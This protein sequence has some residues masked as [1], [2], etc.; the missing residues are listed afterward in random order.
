MKILSPTRVRYYRYL[1]IFILSLVLTPSLA[2][3]QW[4]A[5][6]NESNGLPSITKGGDPAL[7]SSFVF[8]GKDWEWA[9][10]DTL[11][12]I[13][14]PGQYTLRGTNSNLNL[15]LDAKISKV[16]ENQYTWDIQFDAKTAQK[17]IVGGGIE[18]N[19]DLDKYQKD[20][21]QSQI[22][23][24]K[25]G[26]V[27]GEYDGNHI[28]FRVDPK[29]A[30]INFEKGNEGIIRTYFF[31]GNIP[32][33]KTHFKATLSLPKN[34]SITST[35]NERFGTSN[36]D[37]WAKNMLDWES[38]PIDLSFLN[39]DERPAGKH[40]F[41]KAKGDQ[42]EFED[43]TVA[44]FW[45]TN[46]TAYTIFETPRDKVKLQ[47]KRLS[48]LGFNLVRLHHFDSLWV[49]P[50]IFGNKQNNTR[51]I[52]K[53]SIEKI[54]W[55]IKCL[56]DEGIY[57]WLDLHVGRNVTPS[58]NIT[59]FNEMSDGA[60]TAEIKGYNYINQSIQNAM[61]DFNTAYLS[62][63]NVFTNTKY[64]DEPSVAAVLITNE[65]DLTSHFGNTFLP[66]KNVPQH[67]KIFITK[68]NAFALKNNLSV[69]KTSRTWEHGPSKLLLND[70]E[71]Q[72]NINMINHLRKLGLKVP[73]VTTSTWG[74]NPISSLPALTSGDIIDVH[75]YQDIG[76]LEKNPLYAANLTHW[77]SAGQVI[78]KPTSV[79]EWNA[80]PFPTADRHTLP[81]YVASQ[82]SLQGW[83]AMMQYAYAQEALTDRGSPSN[84]QSYNDP[85]L[86][87][88]MPAAALMYRRGDI[89]PANN[90][91]VLDLGKD[92]MF[93]Q[94]IS[95]ENSAFIRT[96][97]ELSKL[98]IAMPAVKELPW[99][100]R[101]DIPSNAKVI[102]DP[103]TSV[104]EVNA[105]EAKSDTNE[106]I[107][108]WNKGNIY[109]NTP[110]T[111]AVAGWIGGEK[112]KLDD[113]E[114]S[115]S[116]PNGTIVVQSAENVPI[117][118]SRKI[119]ISLAGRSVT[120][121]EGK[122]PF[123]SEQINGTI[124]I[125]APKGLKLFKNDGHHQKEV[126]PT[127]YENGQYSIILNGSQNTYW[128]TLTN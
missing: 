98:V 18:F 20:L 63:V 6:L 32:A 62:H 119:L 54:D 110:R 45:G 35:T 89:K 37:R 10:I 95:P 118:K 86:I 4:K 8:W 96:S 115:A 11:F 109:I 126:I 42:L 90:T 26:W 107:R 43:G 38:S 71:Y 70:L 53:D 22:L 50:N 111:Q 12:K 2:Q 99:L 21:G 123:L 44:K 105:T 101:S 127:T 84:W 36:T 1:L 78:N 52:N 69:S 33:G 120:E 60:S 104:I 64:V 91:Y 55:W 102:N 79:S 108:N 16:S 74:G 49:H 34:I 100:Q 97:T 57:V 72:F 77:I 30:Y 56:K 9:S 17:N 14:S 46:I 19:L 117:N 39:Q 92:Q 83:D 67:S 7:T 75:T 124:L 15:N 106:I 88:T 3:S 29:P 5:T 114:I 113:V 59:Y 93:N 112:F 47:A 94:S 103:S 58:D 81:I 116:T 24:N 65:N 61:R 51:S 68:V 41:V 122:M 25:D 23:P 85:S 82:A 73:I 87:A 40:G 121:R 31:K 27:W 13:D 66:D 80:E 48:S 125:K 28:E 76:A 128:M